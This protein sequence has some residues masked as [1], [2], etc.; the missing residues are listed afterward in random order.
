MHAV[1]NPAGRLVTFRI[2]PP[3]SDDNSAQA[4]LDLRGHIV[5]NAEPVIVVSDLLNARTFAPTTTERFAALM[6]SD[7]PKIFRSALLL[8]EDAPT[9]VL[10]IGRMLKEANNPMRRTF[11][12]AKELIEWLDPDLRDDERAALL[13]FFAR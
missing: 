6:K 11:F 4:S 13:A 5:G 2:V 8:D 12:D 1:A 7:N 9:L 10:Q 3:V